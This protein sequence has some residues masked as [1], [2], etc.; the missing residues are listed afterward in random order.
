MIYLNNTPVSWNLWAMFW[1]MPF[2][3]NGLNAI[4]ITSDLTSE[5]ALAQSIVGFVSCG[6]LLYL[7][8]E[9]PH[10]VL[11]F[12]LIVLALDL[13]NA[14]LLPLFPSIPNHEQVLVIGTVIKESLFICYLKFSKKAKN[15]QL[16]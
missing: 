6:Y 1:I 3:L 11:K 8:A 10:K 12:T 14:A 15:Y 5:Y 7:M 2:V 16:T 4:G 9:R 13:F